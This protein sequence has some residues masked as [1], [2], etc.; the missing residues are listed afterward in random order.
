MPGKVKKKVMPRHLARRGVL[1]AMFAHQ[2]GGENDPEKLFNTV[3]SLDEIPPSVVDFFKELLLATLNRE[4]FADEII[5]KVIENWEIERI[6]AVDRNILRIGITEFLDFPSISHKVTIDEAVELA[7]EFG[8]ENSS[9]FVNGV[10][11]ASLRELVAENLVE[12]D[13]EE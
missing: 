4:K 3:L 12:L 8:S 7:K 2:I 11:D 13:G 5:Q 10:I 1:M 6:S 9:K